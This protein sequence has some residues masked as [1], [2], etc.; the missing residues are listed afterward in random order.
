MYRLYAVLRR[1]AHIG[2]SLLAAALLVVGALALLRILGARLRPEDVGDTLKRFGAAAEGYPVAPLALI[3]LL[4]F[5]LVIPV[6]PALVFQMA[7]GLAF[8]PNWGLLYVLAADLLGAA[9]GFGLARRWG[10]RLLRRWVAAQTVERVERLAHRLNWQG[11]VLLRLL[12]GPAYPLVS[13]AA[14]LSR[15]R[16]GAYLLASFA[17]VLPSL[18]LLVLA[19]DVATRS[20]LLAIGIVLLLVASL[21][22]IG[23]V[24]RTGGQEP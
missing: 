20:P 10:L 2:C 13:F 24:L 9:V 17:G 19:G 1:R 12:P 3:A 16:F 23:R 6:L 21:L 18:T 14:G 11:V 5:V 8:G 4:A 7:S 15:L 22:L